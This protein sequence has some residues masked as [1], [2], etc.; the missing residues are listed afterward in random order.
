MPDALRGS[1]SLLIVL[2]FGGLYQSQM[3]EFASTITWQHDMMSILQP[4]QS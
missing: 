2:G 4:L 3:F 1:S